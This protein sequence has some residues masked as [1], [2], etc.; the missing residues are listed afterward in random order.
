M[1]LDPYLGREQSMA[2]HEALCR[3]L[4]VLALK[5]GHLRKNLTIN[6]V[7]AFAGP[8]EAHTEDLSDTS[9]FVAVDALL[10][11]RAELAK[12][13]KTL[14]VRAF[15]VTE[16]TAGE[17]QL[18]ALRARFPEA[19][20]VIARGTFEANIDAASMFVGQGS[21]PYS[22]VFIDPT[23]WTGLPMQRLQRLLRATRGEVLVN[24]MLEFIRR[25]EAQ[26]NQRQQFAEF[27]GLENFRES[28]APLEGDA[29]D[30]QML[31]CYMEQLRIVGGYQHCV[32]APIFN[33]LAD[34]IHFHLVYGTHSIHGLTT[35]RKAE[36]DTL[37][38]QIDA[39]GRRQQQERVERL[40][41]GELFDGASVSTPFVEDLRARYVR[42]AILAV[43]AMLPA[44]GSVSWDA[45]VARALRE[46]LVSEADVKAWL[47]TNGDRIRVLGLKARERVP[48]IGE[49][50]SLAWVRATN[51]P[52]R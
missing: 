23:G 5:I 48:K 27:F 21:D 24:F 9:P 18:G 32:S 7:D 51:G 46:P 39:R 35:F 15:F 40:G 44:S 12:A 30:E 4:E 49:R 20:I 45:I 43:E 26:P 52:Q 10:R 8:W 1:T 17:R 3:D 38:L 42:R 36:A 34:K 13:G 37:D 31:A 11:A 14:R 19:E 50:H 28:W 41:Q 25:F 2:K 29:R 16:D 22:F 6:Y 33:V 47:R